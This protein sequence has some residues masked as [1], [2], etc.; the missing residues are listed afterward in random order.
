LRGRTAIGRT[1]ILVLRINAPLRV[2][3]RD[4]LIAASLFSH[5]GR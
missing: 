1:T 4:E 5:A 2:M 3:L